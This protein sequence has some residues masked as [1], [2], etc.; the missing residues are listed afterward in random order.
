MGTVVDLTG[1][2]AVYGTRLLVEAGHRVVRVEPRGD[3]AV[4][5]SGPRIARGGPEIEAGAF[6]AFH[7][8]GK[9]SLTLD[10]STSGGRDVLCRLLARADAV[11]GTSPFPIDAREMAS[12]SP[13]LTVVGVD[14]EDELIAYARSGLLSISGHPGSEPVV[15][16]G[17]IVYA[18][19]G[20]YVGL[21]A[22]A[23]M[24]A[25]R[26]TGVGQT[27]AVSVR[28]C[29]ESWMEQPMVTYLTTGTV[30]ERRGLRGAITAVSGAFRCRDGYWMV[31]THGAGGWERLVEWI[32]DPVLAGDPTLSDERARLRRR[33]E[34]L[35][36]IT[37]WS[38]SRTRDEI[39]TEA[40]RRHIPASP[41]VTALDLVDDPQLAARGFQ[42]PID[43]PVFG[44][45][46]LPQGAVAVAGGTV[47][48]PA[49][50]LGEHTG[51]I[52]NELGYTADE[53]RALRASGA[54]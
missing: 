19:I 15:L 49:P 37:E 52:L 25:A 27:V 31:S 7:N 14:E 6:H 21:A 34:I 30:N 24:H 11:V 16:G 17:H 44:R 47:V 26:R 3:D 38:A 8:A 1:P 40:Q 46:P 18:A 36:R 20:L 45:I 12:A 28:A 43:H 29:L 42:R 54:V 32:G 4:R 2:S 35:D 41:V 53:Q 5:R 23:A 10:P 48:G 39:V 13:S 51:L 22:A 50:R 33:D 9:E